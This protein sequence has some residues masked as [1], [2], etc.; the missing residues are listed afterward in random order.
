MANITPVFKA[1]DSNCKSNYRPISILPSLSK[2][3]EK[4]LANQINTF[5]EH[6]FSK[7]L[8]GFRKHHSTQHALMKLLQ[9][10]QSCLDS[11]GKI[12]TILMDLSKAFDCLPHDLLL[13][14]L[15]HYGLNE[16]ALHMMESYLSNRKQCVKVGQS[17]SKMRNIYK[18]V[19]QGS[20]LEPVLFNIFIRVKMYKRTHINSPYKRPVL[21]CL[22]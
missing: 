17:V 3:F 22:I 18:G 6:K 4:L 7:Y 9:K 10:W 21:G 8:C 12:G 13:L 19:P 5:F 1:D 20:I 15:K 16:S 11:R 2:V 14:K